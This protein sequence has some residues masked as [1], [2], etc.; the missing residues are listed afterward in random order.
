MLFACA[1]KAAPVAAPAP[2]VPASQTAPAAPAAPV[3][4]K[5]AW[6]EEWERTL[7]A[8]KRDAKVIVFTG[9]GPETRSAMGKVFRERFGI[10][11]EFI[12]GKGA[13][14]STKLITER[15]AGLYT[16]D[17]YIGGG[18]TITQVLH[19]NGVV[20]PIEPALLLPEVIDPKLWR[21]GK[22]PFVGKE[23]TSFMFLA[24]STPALAIN[25]D[26]VKPEE[27]KSF[28]DLL[29]PKWKG[30]I[31]MN[32]PSVRGIGLKAFGFVG[33]VRMGMDFMR[34]LA[35]QE[36]IILRDQ[37]L[38]G[39]WLA[40]G[41]YPVA[42]APDDQ[43]MTDFIKVGAPVRV[44]EAQEGG[45]LT[46]G[47]GH[48]CL[49]NRAPHPNA[50]KVFINWHLSKEGQTIFSQAYGAPSQ[51][52]D[53]PTEGINP[54]RLLKPGVSYFN[55]DDPDFEAKLNTEYA[56]LAKDIFGALMR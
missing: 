40:K 55:G 53:T 7:N 20:D 25:T 24:Y 32:D 27:I 54:V 26:L 14:L 9:V 48:V 34:E 10:L 52:L 49:L 23:R 5:A 21:E 36:P 42:F 37:R 8:A 6:E 17:V 56:K 44:I 19:P 12:T 39:E 33:G 11:P 47:F 46:G 16:G 4:V 22:L 1:P 50:A 18:T 51:R 45:F 38:Q 41:K 35:K 30:K 28:N 43:V 3:P 29:N 13:E 31:V 15:G 2:S